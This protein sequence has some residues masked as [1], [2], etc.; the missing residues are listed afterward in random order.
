MNLCFRD[1]FLELLVEFNQVYSKL[2]CARGCDVAFGVYREAWVLAFVDKK[3]G[4]TSCG[5]RSIVVGKLE[6]G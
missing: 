2:S 1:G 3:G 6:D 5:V 4:N